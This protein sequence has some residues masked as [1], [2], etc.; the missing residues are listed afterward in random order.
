[1]ATKTCWGYSTSEYPEIWNGNCDTR[2]EAIAEG[3]AE[4]GGD[5]FWICDGTQP[6]TDR[7]INARGIIETAGQLAYDEAGDGAVEWPDV[8]KE[9][10]K[11]LDRLL[12]K[13]TRKHCPIHFWIC[14]GKPERVP[15]A[16]APKVSKP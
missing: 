12:A 4:F 11:E 6:D 9:A 8:S 14:D 16:A 1:M 2:E 3:R 15:A 10:E 5:E 13:W 7:F